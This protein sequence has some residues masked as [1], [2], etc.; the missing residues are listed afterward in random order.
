MSEKSI[1][2]ECYSG[3]KADERPVKIWLE[4]E[5]KEI[6]D[7]ED[8]WYSPGET[9]FRILLTNGDRYVLRHVE[10]QDLWTIQAYRAAKSPPR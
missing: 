3:F 7:V 4:G 6:V 2:V 9:F 10:A 8:S 1:H 5:L